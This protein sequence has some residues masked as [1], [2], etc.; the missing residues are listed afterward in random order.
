MPEIYKLPALESAPYQQHETESSS[1]KAMPTLS[2]ALPHSLFRLSTHPTLVQAVDLAYLVG[3]I[4]YRWCGSHPLFIHLHG[5]MV[6]CLSPGS[7]GRQL[8]GT[9]IPP[10]IS[11][12]GGSQMV[13]EY[14]TWLGGSL[15]DSLA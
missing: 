13:L 4:Q 3:C 7:A 14:G 2:P 12:P 8:P 6:P 10:L 11:L 15:A 5:R 1:S 9:F